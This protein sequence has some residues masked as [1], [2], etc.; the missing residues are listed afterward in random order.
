MRKLLKPGFVLVLLVLVLVSCSQPTKDFTYTTKSKEA[1]NYFNQ[2]L[3]ELD[4]LQLDRARGLFDKA[5]ELDPNFAMAHFY[6]AQ[7][8]VSGDEFRHHLAMAVKDMANVTEPEKLAI[9]QMKANSED[10]TG[11]ARTNLEKLV[12]LLPESRRAHYLMGIFYFG[13]QEWANAE[14]EFTTITMLDPKFAPVYNMLA[15]A[16]SNQMKYPEAIDALKTYAELRPSDPN[17]YDSMGEIYLHSGD[18][19]NSIMAY[20]KSLDIDPLFNASHA[21]LGHNYCFTE[22]YDK[23]REHYNMY[24]TQAKSVADTNTYY[25]WTAASYVYEGNKDMAIKTLLEQVEF[26][27][28]RA[29]VANQAGICQQIAL[30]YLENKEYKQALAQVDKA[31]ALAKDPKLQKAAVEGIIRGTDALEARIYAAIGKKNEAAKS[32][33]QMR[34]SA[35]ASNNAINEDNYHGAAGL[36]ALAEGDYKLAIEHFNSANEQNMYQQYYRAMAME[37]AGMGEAAK[38]LY[39]KV[40]NYNRNNYLYAFVREAAMKKS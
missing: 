38:E 35:M 26:A 11:E 12:G 18:Y 4:M 7:T 14:K 8:A 28:V 5:L 16:Y 33:E 21:G 40:A 34:I 20:E 31:R 3:A 39:R 6:R 19:E 27:K 9:R 24:R 23:A 17:P 36:V 30:M 1:L 29:Q 37:K 10:K 32:L 15:Y 22:Q 2:G 25:F 13:Q